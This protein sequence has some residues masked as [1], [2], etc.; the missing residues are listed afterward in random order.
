MAAATATLI[1]QLLAA[2][3][4]GAAGASKINSKDLANSIAEGID[5]KKTAKSVAIGQKGI[6]ELLKANGISEEE[7][8]KD[9]SIIERLPAPKDWSPE[10]RKQVADW[11]KKMSGGR[12]L[13]LDGFGGG[14]DDNND[15]KDP[16]DKI[17]KAAGGT[18]LTTKSAGHRSNYS[19]TIEDKPGFDDAQ[20]IAEKQYSMDKLHEIQ[21]K[22][23]IGREFQPLDESKLMG[24]K[25]TSKVPEHTIMKHTL[26]EYKPNVEAMQEWGAQTQVPA[27]DI[28]SAVRDL[29]SAKKREIDMQV[30]YD[31]AHPQLT[32]EDHQKINDALNDNLKER[33]D[34]DI[35]QELDNIEHPKEVPDENAPTFD[36]KLPAM[37]VAT[38][39]AKVLGADK[40]EAEEYAERYQEIGDALKNI[41]SVE[42]YKIATQMAKDFEKE[43]GSKA[44]NAIRDKIKKGDNEEEK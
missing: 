17:A 39:L 1:A 12:T 26:S 19:G 16:K 15:N 30:K 4:L 43:V 31:R 36:F 38:I 42:D 28:Q 9:K 8:Q 2:M 33:S 10:K 11:Y 40:A 27:K 20:K 34:I 22:E 35:L 32:A 3:G 14:D 25:K 6:S 41:N 21:E 29:E 13:H 7:F 44:M 5:H 23:P 18:T 24:G 37:A